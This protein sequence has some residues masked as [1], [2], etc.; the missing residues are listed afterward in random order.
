MPGAGHWQI[1]EKLC[2]ESQAT[3]NLVPDASFAALSIESDA[4]WVSADA[5]FRKFE[6]M[7]NW[8][9]LRPK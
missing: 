4:V 8:Q 5:D 1:F 9:W 3:G 2:L 7:L 6:P